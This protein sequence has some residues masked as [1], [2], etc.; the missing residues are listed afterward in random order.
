MRHRPKQTLSLDGR[1]LQ[2]SKQLK[3]EADNLPPGSE[4]EQLLKQA[5]NADTAARINGWITSL[6]LQRPN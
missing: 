1:P 6:G 5:R 3:R 2:Q 4:R